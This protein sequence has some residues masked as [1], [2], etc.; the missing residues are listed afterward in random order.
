MAKKQIE[1]IHECLILSAITLEF[2]ASWLYVNFRV[3]LSYAESE[4]LKMF[5]ACRTHIDMNFLEA[6]E[7]GEELPQ[8]K[9][10]YSWFTLLFEN[11]PQFHGFIIVIRE[12]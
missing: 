5:T 6:S 2:F 4:L 9:E 1:P 7:M 8:Y 3:D 12:L 11:N 10:I